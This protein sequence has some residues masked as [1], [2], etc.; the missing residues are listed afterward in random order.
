MNAFQRVGKS[1]RVTLGN[2][3]HFRTTTNKQGQSF[4]ATQ[5]LALNNWYRAAF[6]LSCGAQGH[7]L[8]TPILIEANLVTRFRL[9]GQGYAGNGFLA[10][11]RNQ[12]PVR[13]GGQQS[14][15]KL[16]S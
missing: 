1:P 13:L 5:D 10:P 4:S 7:C 2:Q 16:R 3:L 15:E 11:I 6:H 12:E 9:T 8:N 14:R